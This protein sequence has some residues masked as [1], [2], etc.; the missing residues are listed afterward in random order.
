MNSASRAITVIIINWNSVLYLR[1]C[2]E[3]INASECRDEVHTIVIDNASYDGSD[4]LIRTAYPWAQFVQ[5]DR[6]L[7][8][9]AAN[10]F[11]A[12]L[13]KGCYLLFLNP[14][15]EIRT[16]AISKMVFALDN[17]PAAGAIGCRLLNTDGSLQ[18]SC[19][20]AFPTLV[21]QILDSEWLRNHTQS[22]S[23]WGNSAI[24][25]GQKVPIP[26]D[27]IS[28]ACML[29]RKKYFDSVGGFSSRYFMYSEDLDL[30]FKMHKAGIDVCYLDSAEVV[31]HGGK[32]S[33][34]LDHVGF[35]AIMQ[36]EATW[37]FLRCNRSEMC[38]A[39]FR[40]LVA[41]SACLRLIVLLSLFFVRLGKQKREATQRSK[42]KW[43]SILYWAVFRTNTI[44]TKVNPHSLD[45]CV[46]Q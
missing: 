1:P 42:R 4:K 40:I 24:H 19:V 35:A 2:L 29:I 26:V 15:T 16:N 20:Q 18:T 21:N 31:H 45:R 7:G 27:A 12:S 25:L 46:Q 8:F 11:G 43:C 23:I 9:A 5:L 22:W 28:G 38:A 14:D 37:Q 3:S 32:S 41:I 33:E 10:N 39:L 36:R 34:R 30:C 6:N 17:L 13:A 44:V